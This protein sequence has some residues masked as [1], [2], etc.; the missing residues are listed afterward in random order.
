[1]KA[2]NIE[3]LSQ[4]VYTMA[5]KHIRRTISPCVQKKRRGDSDS[6]CKHKGRVLTKPLCAKG[7]FCKRIA[8]VQHK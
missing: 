6:Y 4:L 3:S 7:K 1:M 8:K 5:T 2:I